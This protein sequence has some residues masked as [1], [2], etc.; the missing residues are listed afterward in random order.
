MALRS[1]ET[2]HFMDCRKPEYRDDF[3][4]FCP[5]Y[6]HAFQPGWL[7][8][9]DSDGWREIHFIILNYSPKT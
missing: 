3:I 8:Y 9:P 1:E 5:V 4:H 2:C 6:H 7:C